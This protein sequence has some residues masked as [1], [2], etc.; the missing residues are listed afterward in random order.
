MS[1]LAIG[2]IFLQYR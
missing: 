2:N 1:Q